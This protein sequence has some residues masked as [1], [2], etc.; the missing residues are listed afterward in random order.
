MCCVVVCVVCVLSVF[1]L[2]VFVVC[3]VSVLCVCVCVVC[4]VGVSWV[5][6]VRVLYL[7]DMGACGYAHKVGL[8]ISVLCSVSCGLYRH[9]V[10]GIYVRS[11]RGI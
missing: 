2:Y 1:V 11:P 10:L 5:V 4:V 8:C 3:V 7:R 6:C 9:V